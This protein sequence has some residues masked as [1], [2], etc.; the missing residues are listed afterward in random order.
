M[1]QLDLTN[2][3]HFVIFIMFFFNILLLYFCAKIKSLLLFVI[4]N[5]TVL[6]K[7]VMNVMFSFFFFT[8]ISIFLAHIY[9]LSKL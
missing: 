1:P 8:R 6:S 5:F 3:A 7:S 9:W 4:T 2:M